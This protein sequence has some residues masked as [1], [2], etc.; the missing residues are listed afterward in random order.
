[1]GA[2]AGTA[3]LGLA[4]A[5][6]TSDD[7]AQQRMALWIFAGAFIASAAAAARLRTLTGI[8]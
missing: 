7:L 2:I 6:S 4:L 1:M 3:I 8:D 5:G